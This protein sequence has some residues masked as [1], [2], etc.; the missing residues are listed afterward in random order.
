MGYLA[1][2]SEDNDLQVDKTSET[3]FIEGKKSYT[4]FELELTTNNDDG[5]E[6]DEI[7]IKAILPGKAYNFNNAKE[8]ISDRNFIPW[9]YS[10]KYISSAGTSQKILMNNRAT[11]IS[12]PE[13]KAEYDKKNDLTVATISIS[14]NAKNHSEI[15]SIHIFFT[16]KSKGQVINQR[17]SIYAESRYFDKKQCPKGDY[18]EN[19]I[20]DGKILRVNKIYCW[21]VVPKGFVASDYTSFGKFHPRDSRI[22]EREYNILYNGRHFGK[23]S[24]NKITDYLKGRPQ[25]I[26]WVIPEKNITF[27]DNYSVVGKWDEIRLFVSCSGFPLETLFIY[28]SGFASIIA[29]IITV[30]L[31]AKLV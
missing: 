21:F 1:I 19:T 27:N 20:I 3:I 11:K 12:T 2:T 4:F 17:G 25:V 29:L 26:N 16:Y 14:I 13:I 7:E 22:I 6:N 15:D 9:Y 31:G 30:V 10:Q 5:F 18:F 23:K 24:I 28:S 8:I